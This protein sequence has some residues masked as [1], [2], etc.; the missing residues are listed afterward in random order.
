MNR[1]R[2]GVI[3]CLAV[4][5]AAHSG[6]ARAAGPDDALSTARTELAA[7]GSGL[8]RVQSSVQR[9]K[10]ERMTA[11]QRLSNGELLF[12]MKDYNRASVVLSEI[13]EEF[14]NTAS[15]PD[16]LW[17][18]GET[19]YAQGEYLS[20]RRDYRALVDRGAEPRFE[21]YFGKALARLVDV[22]LRLNDPPETLAPI[23]EK[24]SQVPPAQ[25]DAALLYAK[26]KALYRQGSYNDA[27]A[28]FSQVGPTTA[29]AHQARYFQGLVAMKIARSGGGAS[30]KSAAHTDYKP[31]V[32]AFHAVTDLPPDTPEHRQVIDL[33]WMAIGRLFY[34]MEQYQ[35]AAEAYSKVGRES[36]EFDTML[37]E[38]AW[39]YVRLGDVDRAE[40][41]LEV[42]AVADPESEYIGDG[43][44]LRADLLLRAGAFDRALQLYDGVRSQYEPMRA[45]V[46]SFLD[47]TK[48]V[49]VYYDR[50]A[51]QQ[52][53]LLDQNDQ[54]P[55]VA[56]RWAREGDDGPLA[57]A[58]IDD[59]NEC[60]TLLHKSDQLV[61]KL[62]ALMSAPTRVRA[63]PDLA[64]GEQTA[65]GLINRISRTRLTLAHALDEEEPSDLGGE[66]GEVRQQR[67]ALMAAIEEL[68]VDSG[69]FAR[70]ERQGLTQWNT[71]SQQLSA[72][73][74]E[75]DT[76]QAT[77][78]GL[79]RMLNDGPSQGVA[80]DPA[81]VERFQAELAANEH[82]LKLYRDEMTEFRR[83][84]EIGRAQIGLGDLRYQNDAASRN[85]FRDALEREVQLAGGGSAGG[86]AQAYSGQARPLLEQARQYEGTLV[87]SVTQIEAQVADRSTALQ[88][89]IDT[90]KANVAGYQAQLDG[91]DNEA[92]DSRGARGGAQL[93]A[94]AGLLAGDR[95]PR[96][97]R[98]HRAGVGGTRGGARP[99][100][101][102]PGR[103]RAARATAR[104]GAERSPRRRRRARAVE[105]MTMASRT[106]KWSGG[107]VLGVSTALALSVSAQTPSAATGASSAPASSGSAST[108]SSA[109]PAASGATSAS[110]TAATAEAVLPVPTFR[111]HAPPLPP[112]TPEQA[113]AYE[114]V[115]QETETYQRGA[116]DYKDAITTIVSLHYEEK[117]KAILGGLDREIGIEKDELKKAR[118][119]A[120]QRLEDFVARY[121]GTNAQPEATPDAMYRLAALY[122]ERARSDDDPN[123]DLAISLKPAISIYRR[124][125]REFPTYNELAGIY[126]FLGHALN[127]SRRVDEAQ[128]VWRSL[129]CHNH[130]K[131]PVPSDPKVADVDQIEPM[132]Q[133]HDDA[134]WK[135]W[136]S[137][138]PT[139][140]SLKKGPK[141][142]A[143]YD[144][145]YPADCAIVP[146]PNVLA[147][148]A[149]KYVA[150]VWW[151][152]GDWE[153]DQLDLRGGVVD[154]EP[155]AVWDYNRAASAYTHS[156]QFKKPPIYGVAL[157]KYA[158]TLFKQQRYESAVREFVHLL[159]YTDEQEKLTG[160]PGADF[161]QEAFTYI[162]GSLDNFD[163]VG[164][165][166]EE[167]YISRPDILDTARSPAEAETKL[168][169]AID[170]VQDPR[171]VPQDK[172]WTI[173]IYKALALEYRAINQYKNA[174]AMYDLMLDKWPMDPSAPDN[175]NAIAE[176]YDLLARQTKAGPER[177]DFEAKVLE[178]RTSLSKYIGDAPWV[179]ANKDNPVALQRAEELVRTGL[180]GA[181]VTHT[182]NGQAALDGA[183][184]TADPREKLRLTTYALQEYKLAAIGWLGYLKQ[185]ENAP[186]AYKSRY[187]YA[188]ALH[189]QVRLEVALHQFDPRTYPEPMSQEIV[190]AERAAIDV[191]DSDEDDQFI[192]NAGLFVVDLAD[193]DRDLA[194]QR[195]QDS[196]GTQGIEAR[197]DPKLEGPD[198]DK[199]VIVDGFPDVIQTSMRARD[200]YI[201]RVPPERDKQNHASDYAFYTADQYYLYGHF[202]QAEPRFEA[203]RQGSL[204]QGRVRVRGVEAAAHD[205]QP[206]EERRA[207]ARARRGREEELVRQDGAPARRGQERPPDRQRP[208]E[209]RLRGREQGLRAGQGRAP[210]SAEGR[211]VAQ[212]R[213]DVRGR[214]QGRALAQGRAGRR[215]QLGVLLQADR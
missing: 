18:R 61:D 99:G 8:D 164:P 44:L 69:D 56:I 83:Q 169:I 195:W 102:P 122:E 187:F 100:A 117:K 16:A 70:R 46:A 39:V 75:V 213:R 65:L 183:E 212:G 186:D 115:R 3:G 132:P 206:P 188:D 90:E 50:L 138:Y 144:D 159:N 55:A 87:A 108:A 1:S 167:P 111:P 145:P 207:L 73:V 59:V 140:Q 64:A 40:R 34:E 66:L 22:S 81:S 191:R 136:R 143:I 190:T 135:A 124:V 175:Q 118:E 15:Y 89:K 84:I 200:E 20:A 53:D 30:D 202:D 113:A 17:L 126:Y 112:P 197:K 86:G 80:R 95:S 82:D 2:V 79:R 23:F 120:I 43:T 101:E 192:D 11:E 31:A 174:L 127:D 156:M 27:I 36:P 165:G 96:R 199:K 129:V 130:Y 208:P 168:R 215:D 19:Y 185:D 91:M 160:D 152:M 131:Y 134:F 177:S 37:Y 201:T 103:T 92:R 14:P 97:R 9:A 148:E 137:R 29:Y 153:F 12:R 155:S 142:D 166:P 38:L 178:S 26:G 68:P 154:Y 63:F 25:V 171:L 72:R 128:Q 98:D 116:T 57:F 28:T 139:P 51:Q 182:R 158:W 32:I 189:Q 5:W 71:L 76:L 106:S 33:S 194:F 172:P 176:V 52:L 209:R 6:V 150:E 151:R 107:A 67:R 54:L 204:R 21:A 181:A 94:R 157:Y 74:N 110:A 42:L 210:R 114:A 93:R 214:A 163:F 205:E 125:I 121:S 4:A 41:A 149:P 104:R 123:A 170:R 180:K 105:Q 48:D 49:S 62:T 45:K 109:A 198:G 88:Q 7:V 60:K 85:A 47:S 193:V 13:L 162:A 184:Q 35:Q 146:Q 78:N 173:E 133:D 203:I 24:F 196:N 161:R 119:T 10:D 77:I 58:T 147:G 211:A 179:D 141:G